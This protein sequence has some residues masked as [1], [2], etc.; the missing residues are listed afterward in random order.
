MSIVS[1][2]RPLYL[3]IRQG[4]RPNA[5]ERPEQLLGVDMSDR[6]VHHLAFKGTELSLSRKRTI[7]EEIS[8]LKK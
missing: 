3:G 5:P 1:A 8:R 2:S 7:D 4:G 6:V